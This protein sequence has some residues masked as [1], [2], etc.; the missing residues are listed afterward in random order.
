MAMKK[1]KSKG[2]GGGKGGKG[3]PVKKTGQCRDCQAYGH[4][5]GDPECPKVMDGTVPPFKP[6]AISTQGPEPRWHRVRK[7]R[8]IA[9]SPMQQ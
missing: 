7:L 8:M 3:K 2:K 1:L 5:S 9:A 6:R 4:W